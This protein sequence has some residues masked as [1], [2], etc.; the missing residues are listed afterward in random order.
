MARALVRYLDTAV[1]LKSSQQLYLQHSSCPLWSEPK[2]LV[3]LGQ[4][5]NIL[6]MTSSS[7]REETNKKSEERLREKQQFK[8]M[9]V[10]TSKRLGVSPH[11]N[12]RGRDC[13]IDVEKGA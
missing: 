12:R 9:E 4:E 13:Q 3:L 1:S 10:E 2:Y 6:C 11:I 7:G 8:I 5:K